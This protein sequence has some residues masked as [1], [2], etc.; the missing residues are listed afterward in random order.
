MEAFLRPRPEA[1]CGVAEFFG[2]PRDERIRREVH[3]ADLV[4]VDWPMPL[5]LEQY[6][7]STLPDEQVGED[8]DACAPPQKL[9]RGRT[10]PQ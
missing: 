6:V 7:A 9:Q 10:W 5:W 4:G 2:V 8:G 3:V 1:G